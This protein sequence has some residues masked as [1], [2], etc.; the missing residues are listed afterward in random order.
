MRTVMFSAVAPEEAKLT[1]CLKS[2]PTD[3]RYGLRN[4]NFK[5]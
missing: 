1:P 3:C 5:A 2:D 4:G